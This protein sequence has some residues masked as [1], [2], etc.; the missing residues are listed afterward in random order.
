MNRKVKLYRRVKT[1]SGWKHLPACIAG[2]G[3]VQPLYAK[4]G[5]KKDVG[6]FELRFYV[7]SRTV[8]ERVG[9][10]ASDALRALHEKCEE[11]QSEEK[12][13]EMKKDADALG[14]T[15]IERDGRALQAAATEYIQ[16]AKD[17]GSNEAAHVY[18]HS[19]MEWIGIVRKTNAAE[20]TEGDMRLYLREMRKR[21]RS[22][23]TIRNRFDHVLSFLA[24]CGLDKKALA[25][26]RPK[27]EK[28]IPEAYTADELRALFT[29]I[30]DAK[31]YNTFQILLCAGLREQEAMYLAWTDV[32]LG[33]GIIKVRSKPEYEFAIKDKEERDVPIPAALVTRLREYREAHPNEKL[34]TGTKTDH[35]NNKL[36]R[37]LK[38]IV[39]NAQLGCGHCEGCRG[40]L[41]ECHRWFLH[42]FRATAITTWHRAGM[43]MRTIMRLSGHS[44]METIMRYLAPRKVEELR[45][46][47]D[48]VQW[49]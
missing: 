4:E 15:V 12:R 24:F 37:T 29:A 20:I 16:A 18:G 22:P 14:M 7:G 45:D 23:R 31:L 26:H 2:N 46:Q 8:F 10:N 5:D 34:V 1:E 39:H 3:R 32:D 17:R 33:K 35:P 27:Y 19:I 48:A 44:D 28:K 9:N 42:R 47:V 13:Q 41:H 40:P 30:K 6:G 38:R 43:D 25:P 11:L 36:L 21:G 49:M